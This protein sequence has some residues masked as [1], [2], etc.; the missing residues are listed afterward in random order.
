[1]PTPEPEQKPSRLDLLVERLAAA[2]P[3]D[4]TVEINQGFLLSLIEEQKAITDFAVKHGW[5]A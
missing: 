1:M 4:I 5:D 2:A 3:D